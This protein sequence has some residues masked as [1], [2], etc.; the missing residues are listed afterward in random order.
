MGPA[1]DCFAEERGLSPSDSPAPVAGWLIRAGA[2]QIFGR[3]DALG[4]VPKL[5][6]SVSR[7]FVQ[8]TISFVFGKSHPLHQNTLGPLDDLAVFHG[9]TQIVG[10]AAQVLELFESTHDNGDSGFQ[11][12]LSNGFDQVGQNVTL[13]RPRNQLSIMVRGDKNNRDWAVRFR[14]S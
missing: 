8:S 13:T 14:A 12:L 3:Q 7:G 2:Q 11:V 1:N 4:N 5:A 6:V 10:L 9:L